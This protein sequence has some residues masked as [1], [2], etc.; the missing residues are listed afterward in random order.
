MLLEINFGNVLISGKQYVLQKCTKK[1][2]AFVVCVTLLYF[3]LF[4]ASLHIHQSTLFETTALQS[5]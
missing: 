2:Y 1:C 3:E 4:M 5:A